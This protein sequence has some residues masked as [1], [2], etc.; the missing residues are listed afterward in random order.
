LAL[1]A[2]GCGNPAP[3]EQGGVN[4][5]PVYNP[6]PNSPVKGVTLENESQNLDKIRG[7]AAQKK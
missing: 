3:N 7:G 6:D 5:A 4:L 2:L 1:L